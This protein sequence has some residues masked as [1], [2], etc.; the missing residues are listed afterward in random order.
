[1]IYLPSI[2]SGIKFILKTIFSLYSQ[3]ILVIC[4][5]LLFIIHSVF[6]NCFCFIAELFKFSPYLVTSLS[7]FYILILWYILHKIYEPFYS[8]NKYYQGWYKICDILPYKYGNSLNVFAASPTFFG[9]GGFILVGAVSLNNQINSMGLDLFID[10]ITKVVIEVERVMNYFSLATKNHETLDSLVADFRYNWWGRDDLP[11]FTFDMPYYSSSDQ[12][13]LAIKDKYVNNGNILRA[14][15]HYTGLQSWEYNQNVPISKVVRLIGES[16]LQGVK[17][18]LHPSGNFGTIKFIKDNSISNKQTFLDLLEFKKSCVRSYYNLDKLSVPSS[19]TDVKL[20]TEPMNRLT[21]EPGR[22]ASVLQASSSISSSLAQAQESFDLTSIQAQP[23]QVG[24]IWPNTTLN[25]NLS[26]N[27][28]STIDPSLL[29]AQP[30][31]VDSLRPNTTVNTSLPINQEST[32]DPSLLQAQSIQVDPL[33]PNTTLNTNLPVNQGSI[34]DPWLQMQ[35]EQHLIRDSLQANA[36]Q[37]IDPALQ[38][39]EQP[40]DQSVTQIFTYDSRQG[41]RPNNPNNSNNL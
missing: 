10:N 37:M 30:I 13:I 6:T 38:N 14:G 5:K 21:Q 23:I 39:T 25:T 18:Y 3:K 32:I 41:L 28:G 35:T 26:V 19:I 7:S 40:Q 9:T 15:I 11:K 29:Q 27:Q 33:W 16:N 12:V 1:M 24:P 36:H 8:K 31:Q 22:Q 4:T 2:F 17:V 20:L 34:I